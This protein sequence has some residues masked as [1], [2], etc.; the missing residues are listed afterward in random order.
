MKMDDL[1]RASDPVP[2]DARLVGDG[3]AFNPQAVDATELAGDLGA[4]IAVPLTA[5]LER[6]NVLATT[7]K[8]DR[9]GLAA[10][11]TEIEAARRAGMIAQQ[12]C[13]L[14]RARLRQ[15]A[16]RIDLSSQLR[17][18]VAQRGREIH[19]RGLEVR[20][21]LRPAEVIADPSLLLSLLQALLDWSMGEARARVDLSVDVKPWPVHA[22]L[23]CRF[24]YVDPDRPETRRAA[25]ADTMA[26][27]LV[28]QASL[29]MGLLLEREDRPGETRVTIEFPRT[30][31]GQMDGVTSIELDEDYAFAPNSKPLA[32]CHVLVLASRREVRTLVRDAIRNMGLMVDF[33]TS[34]DEAREFCSAGLPHAIVYESAVGG[35]AFGQLRRELQGE[36]PTMAFIE[37]GEDG[38]DYESQTYD[39]HQITRVGRDAV[40]TALPSALIFELSRGLPG[41]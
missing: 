26:W 19:A 16:E 13:R 4:E 17:D 10:L 23:A 34:V 24:A 30:V 40:M 3:I 25:P 21:Q 39:G 1:Q 35:H 36:V 31:N 9:A 2:A 12:V 22:R 14:A 15:A 27:R 28:Q 18:A 37:I 20:Q 7:G 33:T 38:R 6:V 41:A 11:R 8:I 32:G 5:A 29:S